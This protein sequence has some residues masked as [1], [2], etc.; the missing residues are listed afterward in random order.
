M[1]YVM[2]M[3]RVQETEPVYTLQQFILVRLNVMVS[4]Q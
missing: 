2:S 1:T 3:L 4:L